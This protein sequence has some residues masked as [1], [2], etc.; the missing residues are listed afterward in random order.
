MDA[1]PCLLVQPSDAS[2]FSFTGT[3]RLSVPP[4]FADLFCA[5]IE[6]CAV[7]PD[8]KL[9]ATVPVAVEL[10]PFESVTV[11]EIVFDAVPKLKLHDEEFEQ[12]CVPLLFHT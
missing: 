3:D 10:C 8:V 4:S 5:L 9:N 1:P 12:I 7:G 11:S 2:T 6:K